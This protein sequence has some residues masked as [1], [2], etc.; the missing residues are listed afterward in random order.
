[1][2]NTVA[3][4]G[5]G[6][7]GDC[8]FLTGPGT[9]GAGT[10]NDVTLCTFRG[11]WCYHENGG[12]I[13]LAEADNNQFYGINVG[14]R[15]SGTGIGVEFRATAGGTR[16]SNNTFY[17]LYTNGG[18]TSRANNTLAAIDN[19][20]FNLSN[21]G[22]IAPT[23]EAGSKL[24]Y[25]TGGGAMFTT[26]LQSS[27]LTVIG[28]AVV[29]ASSGTGLDF[30]GQTSAGTQI[31]LQN[32]T[33]GV[34]GRNAAGNADVELFRINSSDQFNVRA[35]ARFESD[36]TVADTHN[37]LFSGTT[38]TKFGTTTSQKIGFFNANPIVQP[39]NTLATRAALVNL[40]FIASGVT[41]DPTPAVAATIASAT[42]ISPTDRIQFISGT[43]AIA[44]ITAPTGV[45]S[46]GGQI[47]LIPTG[48]F[49]TTTGGNI[50]LASTAVVSKALI[51]TFDQGAN[52][53]YPS[54]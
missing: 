45:A 20:I 22:S 51:M 46:T 23:V 10:E 31:R 3:G 6:G 39:A 11:I 27:N 14:R 17:G 21:S 5:G 7:S 50:A 37:F 35:A 41:I 29:S 25:L 36:V 12:G 19:F 9:G 49:T 43:A 24:Y 1:M 33:V 18:I 30:N 8:L 34:S 28:N 4:A 13:V 47:T 53:W 32:T 44:T 52:K 2:E 26:S 48:I 15:G 16:V 42:T 40:G 38:G 54:Y